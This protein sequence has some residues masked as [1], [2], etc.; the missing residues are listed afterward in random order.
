MTVQK[1]GPGAG[2]P[3]ALRRWAR[4]AVWLLPVWGLFLAASTVTHQPDYD[5]D[6]PGYAEYVTTTWFLISHLLLSIVGAALA[7]LGGTAL[8][9]RLAATSAAAPALWGLSAFA[10]SQVL[11]ASV[12]GVAAFFQPAVGRAFLDGAEPAARAINAD[13]YGP[14]VFAIVGAGLL[15]M[16]VGSVLLGRGAARSGAAPPW[17]GW[18][19]AAGVPVFVVSGFTVTALQPIAGLVVAASAFALA[20]AVSASWPEPGSPAT[21]PR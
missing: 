10:A 3:P 1:A 6:F 19:F 8:G 21:A 4:L 2:L 9:L 17:A 16:M 18:L 15:L 12:F 13:V 20:R 11:T 5:A 14:E 7:V